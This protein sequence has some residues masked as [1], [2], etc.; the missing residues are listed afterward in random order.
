MGKSMTRSRRPGRAGFTLI[1]LLV[2]IG[3][4][5]LLVALL[6]PAVQAARRAQCANNLKQF[7]L[8][9]NN[10]A[11]TRQ[12][13]PPGWNGG[14]YS[15]HAMLLPELE[16][17]A[18][19]NAMNM[20]VD[21]TPQLGVNDPNWTAAMASLQV[22][23]CPSDSSPESQWY[24][25]TNYAGNGGYFNYDLRSGSFNGLFTDAAAGRNRTVGFAA[26]RDGTGQTVAFSE[27]TRANPDVTPGT[28]S[29]PLDGTFRLAAPTPGDT[30]QYEPYASAC[31]AIDPASGQP[32]LGKQ[33]YWIYG[34]YAFTLLM[35]TLPPGGRNCMESSPMMGIFSAGSR[36]RGVV[37]SVFVDGHVGS[38]RSTIAKATWRALGTRSGQEVI[39]SNEY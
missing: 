17:S 30:Q 24:G 32:V 20:S 38:I 13:L 15:A 8:A 16:Q 10:Y 37:N 3:I 9:M 36:H 11:A 14:G 18:L 4:I 35:H 39:S 34:E 1:E 22:F 19:Y 33:C 6:L 25:Q 23:L 29:D 21:M 12:V 27:W 2:V 7:G 5:G 28:D 31:E 26:I